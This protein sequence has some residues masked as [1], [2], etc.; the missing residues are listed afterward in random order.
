MVSKN[1]LSHKL[2]QNKRLQ[3]VDFQKKKIFA[4]TWANLTSKIGLSHELEQI[5]DLT[6]TPQIFAN[7]RWAPREKKLET[8]GRGM[9]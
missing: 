6:G 5:I 2:G 8:S 9:S 3:A 4:P 1:G 7:L